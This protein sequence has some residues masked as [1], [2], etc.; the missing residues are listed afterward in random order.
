MYLNQDIHHGNLWQQESH[1]WVSLDTVRDAGEG[2]PHKE[3][4][5]SRGAEGY[6]SE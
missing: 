1:G 2:G 4:V 3:G 6:W 5:H